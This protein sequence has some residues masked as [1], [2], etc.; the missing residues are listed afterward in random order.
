MKIAF[1][2]H[3]GYPSLYGGV[4]KV[5]EEI[6]N[7]MA[8]RGHQC[9]VYSRYHYTKEIIIHNNINNIVIKGI[10]SRRLDTLSHTFL[11]LLD[12]IRRD[13]DVVAIHSFGNAILNF[14]PKIFGI[15][16]ALH[17]H[18]F[19]WGQT[20]FN[21]IERKIFLRLP[22]MTLKKFSDAITTVSIEQ[23][24]ELNRRKIKNTL[25][26][27]GVSRSNNHNEVTRIKS[28]KYF[29]YVGRI[30]YQKGI[31]TLIKAY[32]ECS[33]YD[34]KLKIVG[35]HEHAEK[36]Y[37]H[38]IDLAAGN[39]NIEFLGYKY[40]DELAEIYRNAFAIVI[41]SESE[42]CP[43]VLLESLSFNKCII[44]SNI[45]GISN[46][47][48]DNVIYFE[49]K[50]SSDL[51]DK[52][53][54]VYKNQI[55][56]NEYEFRISKLD[57]HQFDWD[58]I[59]D[60]YEKLYHNVILKYHPEKKKYNLTLDLD[61]VQNN[62][63]NNKHNSLQIL[64]DAVQTFGF[65]HK[66]Y[67]KA[68]RPTIPSNY[69]KKFQQIYRSNIRNNADVINNIKRNDNYN[70]SLEQI[71][72]LY[73]ENKKCAVVIT[74]D[75]DSLEGFKYI[76]RIL[77]LSERYNIKSCWY[78]I[79]YKYSID[80]GIIKL[81][82]DYGDEIGIHGFNHDGKL[83]I[84]YRTFHNRAKLINAAIKKYN[85]K[86]FRSPMVHRNLLW[87]QELDVEYDASCFD[88]DP[89]QPFPG[90]TNTIWP[91]KFLKFI[92]LPYTIP[93]D[94]TLFYELRQTNISIWIKKI[95]WIIKNNGMILSISHPDYLIEKNYLSLFEHLLDYVSNIEQSWKCLPYEMAEW[96]NKKEK[97][98][99]KNIE[100][101]KHH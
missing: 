46:I 33:F 11:S 98:A 55:I 4:E 48:E 60:K 49:N 92:E 20:R 36:Y 79:P 22:I 88:Y 67:Y 14:I 72:K 34:I 13:I 62:I 66:I 2:G 17:L 35:G 85:A 10:K 90:G 99:A 70:L 9:Y 89:F 69:R 51:A 73:P 23:H 54:W 30:A 7:R 8:E 86:G 16:V 80:E 15:P 41:P 101:T 81:I 53:K 76:P 28:E 52:L 59:V 5:V 50:N 56:K 12:V 29:L 45:P 97:Q 47:A 37:N 25:I 57:M 44:A 77:E 43:M 3:K 84:D 32:V 87:L 83:F 42:E 39:N 95:E 38:L 64:N 82:K 19:E 93:Q 24:K 91:F 75:V 21:F 100:L 71:S 65:K 31:D 96:W 63:P 1:I 61:Y 18:G 26:P 58:A 94:H 74:H 27:N 68:I 6:V 78:I 40:G